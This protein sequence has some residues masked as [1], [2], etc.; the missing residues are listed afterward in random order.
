MSKYHKLAYNI[1]IL[2]NIHY[3][4]YIKGR[5]IIMN[6]KQRRNL[7]KLEKEKRKIIINN[8]SSFDIAITLGKSITNIEDFKYAINLLSKLYNHDKKNQFQAIACN[9]NLMNSKYYKQ[10]L[11]IFMNFSNFH[12]SQVICNI[13]CN[14]M[15]IN[16]NLYSEILFFLEHQSDINYIN[17]IINC[18]LIEN[19]TSIDIN[20]FRKIIQL[21]QNTIDSICLIINNKN[22]FENKI[23]DIIFKLL[24]KKEIDV[25]EEEIS[26]ILLLINSIFNLGN[27]SSIRKLLDILDSELEKY[28]IIDQTYIKHFQLKLSN[29]RI[30]IAKS[31]SL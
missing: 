5:W 12:D 18:I 30:E 10:A 19:I 7:L 24:E 25:F 6:I 8:V 29:E 14:G 16:S 21:S 1:D 20:T 31:T 17:K 2:I 22:F 15:L 11:N 9:K 26:K 4:T 28:D 27:K 13:L 23:L 3:I